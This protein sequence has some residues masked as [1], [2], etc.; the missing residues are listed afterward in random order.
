MGEFLR[1]L[2]WCGLI[3]GAIGVVSTVWLWWL[4]RDDSP[5]ETRVKTSGDR[6]SPWNEKDE[7]LT[8]ES[9]RLADLRRTTQLEMRGVVDRVEARRFDAARLLGH[10]PRCPLVK[11]ALEAY[12]CDLG[13]EGAIE[14]ELYR[15]LIEIRKTKLALGMEPR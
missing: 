4:C 2:A 15:Q 14:A 11:D 5:T 8:S 10:N 3:Y 13:D 9:R 7:T 12:L 6:G 1:T